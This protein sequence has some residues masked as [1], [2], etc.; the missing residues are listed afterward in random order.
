[1]EHE[2]TKILLALLCLGLVFAFPHDT[3]QKLDE[4][5]KRIQ[6]CGTKLSTTISI[7]CH[8]Y[9]NSYITDRPTAQPFINP[10]EAKAMLRRK[11]RGII[12]ECCRNSC[13]ITELKSFCGKP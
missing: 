2:T 8:G 3:Q 4:A 5:E 1:M 7:V 10:R 13:T 9:Y 11:R 12:N 6:Y